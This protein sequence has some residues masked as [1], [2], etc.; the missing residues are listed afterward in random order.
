MKKS[1][2]IIVVGL[3]GLIG[4]GASVAFFEYP[5]FGKVILAVMSVVYLYSVWVLYKQSVNAEALLSYLATSPE[6]GDEH[7]NG[8]VKK[9]SFLKKMSQLDS[10]EYPANSFK[11]Y[12]QKVEVESHIPGV[13]VIVTLGLI[14]TFW[15]LVQVVRN[16]GQSTS[17]EAI[18]IAQIIPEIFSNLIG[19]FGTSLSGLASSILLGL[20]IHQRDRNVVEA[21]IEENEFLRVNVWSQFCI[22]KVDSQKLKQTSED[23]IVNRLDTLNQSIGSWKGDLIKG[24]SLAM[25]ESLALLKTEHSKWTSDFDLLASKMS[26]KL[27]ISAEQL[28]KKQEESLEKSTQSMDSLSTKLSEKLSDSAQELIQKQGE[29]LEKSTQNMDSL[30]TKLSSQLKSNIELFV[31]KQTE[32]LETSS[33]TIEKLSKNLSEELNL[34]LVSGV[35]LKL[36]AERKE[37][38]ATLE[39]WRAEGVAH[40]ETWHTV[41]NSICERIESSNS[42]WSQS[43][44]NVEEEMKQGQNKLLELAEGFAKQREVWVSQNESSQDDLENIMQGKMDSIAKGLED[45]SAQLETSLGGIPEKLEGAFSG[46]EEVSD[47][48]TPWLEGLKVH[49]IQMQ[50]VFEQFSTAI[51]SLLLTLGDSSENQEKS[52]LFLDT[53]KEALLSMKEDSALALQEQV[54]TS[55]EVLVEVLEHLGKSRKT[56]DGSQPSFL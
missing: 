39:S 55:N 53:L 15:G 24:Q 20:I 50:S 37:W 56:S 16:A 32:V 7:P 48:I 36:E 34:S 21:E 23:K 28:V 8:L 52:N 31:Q 19:I 14:G 41:S 13:S 10:L 3:L 51:E 26:E 38:Q 1:I 42:S 40:V 6:V 46:L 11:S 2:F 45:W 43:F 4:L 54:Q 33:Q 47:N 30:S 44:G 29:S 18:N 25:T 12:E 35:G 5:F 17:S 27:S 49:Q 9:V 22:D